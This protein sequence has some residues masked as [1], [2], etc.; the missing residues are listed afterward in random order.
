MQRCPRRSP[1]RQRA[2]STETN[3]QR[4][5]GRRRFPWNP[6]KLDIPAL[7]AVNSG[8]VNRGEEEGLLFVDTGDQ[9]SSQ[10][11][12]ARP[13]SPS[14]GCMERIRARLRSA[15]RLIPFQAALPGPN[16]SIV[17]RQ[18]SRSPDDFSQKRR[19]HRPSAM[20][21]SWRGNLTPL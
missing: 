6:V 18:V 3:I 5:R 7:D 12:V 14:Y 2:P 10:T 17:A 19:R 1:R 21:P 9:T 8:S 15:N 16:P 20:A 4:P 11:K 13:L